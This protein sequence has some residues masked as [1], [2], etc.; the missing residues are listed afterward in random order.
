M[1]QCL[2]TKFSIEPLPGYSEPK[3]TQ[4][5]GLTAMTASGSAG[6]PEAT[7]GPNNCTGLKSERPCR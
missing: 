3:L 5:G 2:Y 1:A 6:A 4:L 7:A